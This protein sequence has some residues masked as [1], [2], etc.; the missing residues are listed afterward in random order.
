MRCR[1]L[2]VVPLVVACLAP[3]SCKKKQETPYADRVVAAMRDSRAMG[4]RGQMQT[5]ANALTN[6]VASEG[7]LPDA[8]DMDGLVAALQPT[9]IHVAPNIDP[10]GT[11]FR[12]SAGEGG[13][14]L[15]SA[16]RNLAFGD[17]DDLVMENGQI[18]QV[19]KAF[20]PLGEAGTR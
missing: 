3:A 18:T 13:W 5:L 4:A 19:P 16:G 20:T 11:Q 9:W 12:Y 15:R 10:W 8:R 14:T 2:L 17:D 6:Y 1:R 7:N